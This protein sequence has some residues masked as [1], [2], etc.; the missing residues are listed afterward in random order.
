MTANAQK[1][2]KSPR[3][4]NADNVL[5]SYTITKG[6]TET[7]TSMFEVEKEV[8]QN[9]IAKSIHQKLRP[10]GFDTTTRLKFGKPGLA[11]PIHARPAMSS[12]LVKKKGPLKTTE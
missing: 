8:S 2:M 6:N 3:F 5:A 11:S 4:V 7:L 9:D 12:M 10:S 1:K